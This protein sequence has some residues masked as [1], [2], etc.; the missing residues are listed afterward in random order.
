MCG[1][2]ITATTDPMAL[3]AEV[4]AVAAV[5]A[6]FKGY[7]A[8]LSMRTSRYMII[9]FA[10][11][12]PFGVATRRLV[13]CKGCAGAFFKLVA[14]GFAERKRRRWRWW[15]RRRWQQGHRRRWRRQCGRPHGVAEERCSGRSLRCNR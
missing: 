10:S 4:V 3:L 13:Q 5:E 8:T 9:Y 7:C 15:R 12:V 6:L 2:A 1:C 14:T 11:R